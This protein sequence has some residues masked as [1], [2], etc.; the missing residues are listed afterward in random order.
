MIDQEQYTI[1]ILTDFHMNNCNLV[2]TPCP[3]YHL[4]TSM[5]PTTNEERQSAA[6]LPYC[7]VV[8]KCMYLSNC[9]Q[10]DISFT[11][12]ELAK[13]MSNYGTKHYKAAKHLLQYL[14]GTCSWGIIYGNTPNSLPIF[15]A[16]ANSDWAM[17]EGRKS[18]SGFIIECANGPLTWS[19]KQQV[20]VT[21][22][23]CKAEYL[24]C[25]HCA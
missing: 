9:M 20:I 19:S 21:L 17:S 16:F 24:A 5:C 25:S 11:V 1:H 12:R 6:K 7:T 10:P 8:R 3:S 4:T 23:S 15:K 22:S 18:V 13:F 14:Q 2:K